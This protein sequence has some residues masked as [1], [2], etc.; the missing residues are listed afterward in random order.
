LNAA[1]LRS[2]VVDID[3]LAVAN[4]IDARY[5]V[6][7]SRTL[8][9][10]H[11][12]AEFCALAIRSH[13]MWVFTGSVGVGTDRS[14]RLGG[15]AERSSGQ[16]EIVQEVDGALRFYWPESAGDRFDEILLSGGGARMP[17]V[18]ASLAERAG[19]PVSVIQSLDAGSQG[20]A[21]DAALFAVATGLALRE[22]VE[23]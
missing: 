7:A 18:A 21:Y 15:S 1:G 12:G 4:L 14:A 2:Q 16:A 22:A 8:G 23:G 6:D 3:S 20:E 10:V 17:Q 5:G 11:V 19:C 13:G 9:V